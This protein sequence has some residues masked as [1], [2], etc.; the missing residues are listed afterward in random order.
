MASGS[1]IPVVAIS[2][3][4]VIGALAT[5]IKIIELILEKKLMHGALSSK[6]TTH[7]KQQLSE[8]IYQ[9][10]LDGIWFSTSTCSKLLPMML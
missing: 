9:P 8:D 7:I 4:A 2:V 1:V 5:I 6:I 10:M 3:T